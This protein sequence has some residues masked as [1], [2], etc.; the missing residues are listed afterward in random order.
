MDLANIEPQKVSTDLTTYTSM[1]YG[2]PKVGKS[3]FYYELFG[4]RA[5]FGR[6]EKGSKAIPG[7]MGQDI[8]NWSDF[9]KFKQQLKRKEV[10][11]M[12]DAVVLDTYDNL[13]IYLERFIKNKYEVDRLNE[14]NGGWGEGQNE[15]TEHMMMALNEIESYGYTV[16][17]ISHITEK[18]ET[19]PGTETEY[20]KYIPAA[21]K[22]GMEVATKM[23]DNILFGYL[24]IDPE[25]KQEK[26]ALYTRESIHFQAGT[27][28]KNL[29]SPLP[30]SAAAYQ[31]AVENSI[32][33]Y[34]P[35]DIKT[36][37]EGN[38]VETQELDFEAMMAEAKKIAVQ[39]HKLGRMSEV[40][41]IV[42][43]QLG[44]GK[45]LRDANPR[46]IEVVSVIHDQLKLIEITDEDLEKIKQVDAEI[47][48]KKA[49]QAETTATE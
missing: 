9:M 34:P 10:K 40:N 15:F 2:S 42:E 35:E 21:K 38:V 39:L 28:F 22:R 20:T 12:F 18:S 43:K 33:Q 49:A 26:R 24:T 25:T 6:T 37:R 41:L 23:V 16:H 3:T 29:Q 48:A 27:R 17:F 31:K 8:A 36:E 45:L 5:I 14:A 47:A 7:L 44:S 11:A 13:C 30:F 46:Q 19:L 1:L 4:K 32:A